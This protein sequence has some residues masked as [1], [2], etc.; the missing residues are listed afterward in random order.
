[1]LVLVPSGYYLF[2]N[3]TCERNLCLDLLFGREAFVLPGHTDVQP[4]SDVSRDT[5][6]RSK[7]LLSTSG[8]FLCWTQTCG[9]ALDPDAVGRTGLVQSS[10]LWDRLRY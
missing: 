5:P 3:K 1:M 8:P 9:P 7:G 10:P 6:R 4:I 2:K